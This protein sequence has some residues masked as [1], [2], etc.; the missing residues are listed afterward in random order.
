MLNEQHTCYYLTCMSIRGA[1]VLP[2]FSLELARNY[3]QFFHARLATGI[4]AHVS[5]NKKLDQ[6]MAKCDAT[7]D[8]VS[9]FKD[10]MCTHIFQAVDEKVAGEGGVNH[11]TLQVSLEGLKNE[12]LKWLE[13]VSFNSRDRIGPTE[14]LPQVG[15]PTCQKHFSSL[16]R[17]HSP[18][19]MENV[20]YRI[21]FHGSGWYKRMATQ[22]IL[23]IKGIDLHSP[24]LKN[25]HTTQWKPIF[26]M[27][28]K[29]PNL[30]IPSKVEDINDKFIRSS[31]NIATEYSRSCVSYIF[32]G[33]Q[34]ATHKLYTVGTWLF[35]VKPSVVKKRGTDADK[36]S[37]P[38]H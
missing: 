36:A 32:S 35:K 30:N 9:G 5:H 37:Q 34:E 14:D 18:K 31:Y 23:P 28:E 25:M 2:I 13:S 1:R 20:A 22:I 11:S 10:D 7:H 6:I 27:M 26:S 12:I 3:I 33:T 17:S 21:K 29:A 8:M 19:W 38:I 16:C 15:Q 24:A 4:P